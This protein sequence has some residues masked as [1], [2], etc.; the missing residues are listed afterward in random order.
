ME[1]KLT[2]LLNLMSKM[3]RWVQI[4]VSFLVAVLVGIAVFFSV[5]SCSSVRAVSYGNGK[6]STTV[7]Q[8]VADSLNIVVHFNK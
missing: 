6:L 2:N 3:P 1:S 7:S 8:S 4:F 5:P